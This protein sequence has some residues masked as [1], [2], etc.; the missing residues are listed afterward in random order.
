MLFCDSQVEKLAKFVGGE[1]STKFS[2]HTTHLIV[3][4]DEENKADKTLKYLCALAAGKWVVS[5]QWVQ[6]C[7]EAG[8]LLPEVSITFLFLFASS[9]F[10]DK[11]KII[12][13]YLNIQKIY[14]LP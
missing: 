11:S 9:L 10:Y 5:F 12:P 14:N 7:L 3:R 8:K 6:K 4:V 2:A 13:I 1:F